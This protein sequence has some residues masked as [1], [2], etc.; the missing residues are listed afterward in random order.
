M[1]LGDIEV[2]RTSTAEPTQTGIVWSYVKDM[3]SYLVLLDKPQKI[4]FDLGN[5]VD[6]T[7]TGSWNTTLTATYFTAEDTFEAA[8]VILPVSAR[9]S[10]V[11]RPSQ[12]IVPD[13][14]AVSAVSLPANT[15]RAIFSISACGQAAEEFWW[16]NVFTS[17]TQVFGN[18]STLYGHT[19]FRELQLYV[20]GILAGVA[21]PF[22]VIF[23]GGVVPGFWR[24]IVGID[25]FDLQEDQIDISPF[26]PLLNNGGEHTLE[27]R[28]V[29]I[30]DDGSGNG[31]F[32]ENIESSW[33]VTGKLFIWLDTDSSIVT[34]FLPVVDT[35]LPSIQMYS[36]THKNASGAVQSLEYSLQVSRE[37]HIS[38]YLQTSKGH[39]VVSWT[40]SLDYSSR[41]ILTNGGNDQNVQQNTIG[42]DTSSYGYSKSYAY[43]LWVDSTYR[44]YSNGDLAIDGQMR[45]G[46]IVQQAGDLAFPNQLKT[47]HHSQLHSPTFC[48]TDE[49]N[50]QNGTAWYRSTS[51]PRKSYGSGST[52]QHYTLSGLNE[53]RDTMTR[54]DAHVLYKRDIL[55]VNG[56]VAYDHEGLG[57]QDI[58][59]A[60]HVAA[61]G[62][63]DSEDMD[64]F[65]EM[66]VRG[67][68]GRGPD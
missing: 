15:K 67:L 9:R 61:D 59:R 29:G 40:Q 14:R 48:G 17:D 13:S 49:T 45:R 54:E 1:F 11:D 5:L 34:G 50:W 26:I 35:P 10:A 4:V 41:G 18:D 7:Y 22:P 30:D 66:T 38:T 58:D 60:S 8:D 27:I 65:A 33:I 2:F 21:W 24:P 42:H 53:T 3:S 55:A 44:V 31:H 23:T 39:E 52:E 20:D 32:T 16:S 28:V 57:V 46:K 12:F 25:T 19:P 47:V 51:V 6:E 36:T 43:P 56:S 62:W 37:L 68:L 64:A 63:T